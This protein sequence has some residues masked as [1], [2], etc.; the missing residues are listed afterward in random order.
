MRRERESLGMHLVVARFSQ[1]AAIYVVV[2]VGGGG[3]SGGDD[4]WECG[5]SC[6]YEKW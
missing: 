5:E 6:W 3:S 4:V 1:P 2:V